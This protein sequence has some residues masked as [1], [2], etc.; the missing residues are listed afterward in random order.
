[1]MSSTTTTVPVR[2]LHHVGVSVRSLPAALAW[3]EEMFGVRPDFM[4]GSE[5]PEVSRAVQVPGVVIDAAFL[6][7]GDVWL[8]LLEFR[9]PAGTDFTLRNCDVGVIH[10]AL[11][12]PDIQQAYSS[13][14][15]KGVVFSNEPTYIPEGKLAG[16]WY[17]YFRDP[18]NVQF[19]LFQPP[20]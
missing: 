20:A 13:L 8:E 18:D 5:G 6:R 19:E 4:A 7:I 15:S 11:D 10:I 12:V 1:M 2:K 14:T 17:A 3:Y 9:E 16:H